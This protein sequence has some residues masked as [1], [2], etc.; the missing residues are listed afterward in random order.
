VTTTGNGSKDQ[1]AAPPLAQGRYRL[2]EELG[3]GGAARVY[4]GLDTE[5]EAPCA[6][7]VLRTRSEHGA[8]RDR[9]VQEGELLTRL[10]HP[11][12]VRVEAVGQDGDRDYLV[13][14]LMEGGSLQQRLEADGPMDADEVREV[15][16]GLLSAL[17][18]VHAQGVVHR[19][20]KPG[21]VLLDREGQAKLGD[22]GIARVEG[23]LTHTGTTVGTYAFMAPEQLDDP[24]SVG[25]AA[26]LYGAAATAVSLLA[27]RPPYGLQYPEKRA[28]LLADAP[29][30]LQEV[31]E[32]GLAL[33]PSDRWRSA[34]EMRAALRGES[35]TSPRRLVLPLAVVLVLL[36][37]IGGL[38]SWS[39]DETPRSRPTKPTA[40]RAVQPVTAVPEVDPTAG[41][42]P[43]EE[44]PDEDSQA[45]A[46][47]VT[48]PDP[49]AS[50]PPAPVEEVAELPPADSAPELALAVAD[51]PREPLP[52][53]AWIHSLPWSELSIDGVPIG[54]TPWSGE[55]MPGEYRVRL[56]LPDGREKVTDLAVHPESRTRFC[57]DFAQEETCP[58][59]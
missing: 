58:G 59:R 20:V 28:V 21:N 35:L 5:R 22:F 17:E 7:K 51:A 33:E 31:L 25:P 50:R 10:A 40:P 16:D 2:L 23:S 55:L 8:G 13:M 34:T 27:G 24:R 18:V 56:V 12:L 26:D 19:D 45:P 9:F 57:W 36:L 47:E 4:R 52:V 54:R 48:E 32:R 53:D 49:P 44:V 30:D 29:E 1:D 14:E 15:L 37:A 43:V 42:P 46:V 39:D 3:E 6:V 41:A 11:K 38:G